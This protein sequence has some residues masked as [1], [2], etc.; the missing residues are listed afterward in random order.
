MCGIVGFTGQG[1]AGRA[2][3]ARMVEALAHRGPDGSGVWTADGVVLGHTRLAIIDLSPD[4]LQ[5]FHRADA[6]LGPGKAGTVTVTGGALGVVIDARGRP[7]QIPSDPVRRR[8]LMKR[9]SYAV[10]G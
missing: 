3:A 6:G 1:G 2:T 4:A 7:L 8:E 5:P 10:G 9:W